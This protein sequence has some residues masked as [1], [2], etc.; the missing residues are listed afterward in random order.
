MNCFV[1][2]E[3]VSQPDDVEPE[4]GASCDSRE[5]RRAHRRVT[6]HES[7]YHSEVRQEAV[8]QVLAA[9]QNRPKPSMPMPSK[10]TSTVGPDAIYQQQQ[11]PVPSSSV[12]QQK[13]RDSLEGSSD[14]SS[15]DDDVELDVDV[16]ADSLDR[17][18]PA[19]TSAAVAAATPERVHR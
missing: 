1:F 6:R 13:S 14:G 9:M 2:Q 16:D 3:P 15:T 7:R 5:R 19:V 8:Q 4:E 18:R 11:A 17:N 10:R 12:N